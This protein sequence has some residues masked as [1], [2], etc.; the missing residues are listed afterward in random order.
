MNSHGWKFN[1]R[2]QTCDNGDVKDIGCYETGLP[3]DPV[4]SSN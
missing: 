3:W 4:G 2:L 1:R